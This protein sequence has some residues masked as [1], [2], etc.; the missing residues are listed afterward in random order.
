VLNLGFIYLIVKFCT[1]HIEF[2]SHFNRDL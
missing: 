2:I 1:D